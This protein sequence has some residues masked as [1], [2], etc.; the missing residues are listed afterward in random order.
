MPTIE[1][2][3]A[4]YDDARAKYKAAEDVMRAAQTALENARLVATGLEGH[5]VEYDHQKWRGPITVKRFVVTRANNG[6]VSGPFVKKDGTISQFQ[7]YGRPIESV[8]D[9]GPYKAPA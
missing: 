6:N 7:E 1:E 9:L 5:L 2:L 8:R 4:S 3:Q